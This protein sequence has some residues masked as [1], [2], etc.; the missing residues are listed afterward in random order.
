MIRPPPRSTRTDTCFP[1]TPLFRSAV[2]PS[3]LGQDV[4][5][6]DDVPVV[7]GHPLGTELTARLFAGDGEEDQVTPRSEPPLGEVAEGHSHRGGQVEHVD[8][9]APPHLDVDQL[10]SEGVAIPA[11]VAYRSGKRVDH[12]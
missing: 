4:V 2:E 6:G 5:R 10:A 3:A 12:E 8:R 1:Y 11:I 9:P 7:V